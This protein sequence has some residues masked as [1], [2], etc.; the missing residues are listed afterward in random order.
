M[1]PRSKG[2][3]A[4][5]EFWRSLRSEGALVP[6]RGEFHP[7]KAARFLQNIVLLEA[8][9]RDERS[10]K[11]RVAG[12]AYQG[13]VQYTVAGT[14][15][16]DI[17]PPRYH[18]GALTSVRLMVGKPCGLWQVMPVHIRGYSRLVEFTAFPLAPAADG[19]SLI[20]GYF[21]ALD[22]LTMQPA[23]L[24]KEISVDTATEFVFI[25]VGAG[26]PRWPADA[27]A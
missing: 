21:F 23:P 26:V 13:A 2:S 17:L 12:H 25:D 20:L 9:G 11:M 16:L 4:F 10:L 24:Q 27:A 1:R 8:P 14:D 7:A 15:H 22:E 19:I 5:E 18:E 6:G 3:L